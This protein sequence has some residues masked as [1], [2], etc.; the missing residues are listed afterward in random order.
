MQDLQRNP[1]RRPFKWVER[2]P[3]EHGFW[4]MLGAAQASALIRTQA[5]VASVVAALLVT[6][7]VVVGGSLCH[8]WIR[9]ASAAQLGAAA[10]LGLSSVPV[11]LAGGLPLPS[12]ASAGF[13]RIVVFLTSALLVRAAFARSARSGERRGLL[14]GGAS[15]AIPVVCAVL[16][17]AIGRT[18][19][20][21]TCVIASAACTVF[22]FSRPTVKQLKP[23]GLVLGELSLI[24]AITLA[25]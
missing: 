13:A 23:L 22:A 19:E 16:L 11:E 14:L 7:A 2:L 20:G 3:S 21:G 5:R 12:V 18:A 24:T 15:L 6:S 9:K 10:A 1:G 25:L 4:V 8:R 17:F